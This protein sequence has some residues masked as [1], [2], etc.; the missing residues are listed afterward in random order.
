M[1][2][3][4]EYLCLEPRCRSPEFCANLQRVTPTALIMH[5]S[6]A[7]RDTSARSLQLSGGESHRA[8]QTIRLLWLSSPVYLDPHGPVN[9]FFR[10][11]SST[12]S[13][14]AE[15]RQSLFGHIIRKSGGHGGKGLGSGCYRSKG[16][17]SN[18]WV[19]LS[20]LLSSSC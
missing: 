6:S 15:K 9:V 18:P 20:T 13:M 8:K 4:W 11:P 19:E 7:F 3:F 5:T 14:E 17:T 2:F 10:S 1:G 16:I 12:S